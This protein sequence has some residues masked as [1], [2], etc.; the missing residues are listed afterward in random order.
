MF[1]NPRLTLFRFFNFTYSFDLTIFNFPNR[2]T[3]FMNVLTIWIKY[4]L[5]NCLFSQKTIMMGSKN[6][7]SSYL[8]YFND[9]LYNSVCKEFFVYGLELK[10]FVLRQAHQGRL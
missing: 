9:I 6:Y 8:P 3:I 2:F 1:E 7:L 5:R 4:H 10:L